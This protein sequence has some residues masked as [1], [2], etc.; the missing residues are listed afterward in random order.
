MN[1]LLFLCTGNYYRSCYGAA[2]DG[3][4][5][6]TQSRGLAIE[7]GVNNVGPLSQFT[8]GALQ[9]RGLLARGANRLPQRCT[10]VDLEAA[11]Q[12]GN[13][14]VRTSPLNAATFSRL[15]KVARNIGK[16]G[17]IAV[18]PPKNAPCSLDSQVDGLLHRLVP[19]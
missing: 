18:M 19:I 15:G 5:R 9:E 13:E 6:K 12:I 11:V 7:R 2:G 14:R 1:R 17:D 3:L 8:L 16:L 4:H 10:A